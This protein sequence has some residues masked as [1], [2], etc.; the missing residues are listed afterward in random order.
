[1][2]RLI[3]AALVAAALLAATAAYAIAGPLN[4]AQTAAARTTVGLRATSLGKV[5]VNGRGLTLYLFEKDP[6]GRSACS[7]ACASIWPPL[8]ASG[9]VTA[10]RGLQARLFR[11]FR[12]ADGRRQVSYN[13]HALYLYAGDGRPGQTTGEGLNQFGGKWYVLSARGVKIDRG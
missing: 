8:M 5:L 13:G 4:S 10:G 9:N 12:R 11:T 7:G 2:K 1:M 3:P 6:R